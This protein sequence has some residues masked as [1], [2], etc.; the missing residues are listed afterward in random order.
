MYFTLLVYY[1]EGNKYNFV[2]ALCLKIIIVN[3]HFALFSIYLN[4]S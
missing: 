2:D 1:T 3:V 4:N